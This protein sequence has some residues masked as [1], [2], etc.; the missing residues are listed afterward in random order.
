[1]SDVFTAQSV[2]HKQCNLFV[3]PC[4]PF[5]LRLKVNTFAVPLGLSSQ[6]N[7]TIH[8]SRAGGQAPSP[9]ASAR[10]VRAHV[11]YSLCCSL[12]GYK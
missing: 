8:S 7:A 2:L 5:L 11:T 3:V 10:T 1:M 4:R 9:W 12:P 6:V